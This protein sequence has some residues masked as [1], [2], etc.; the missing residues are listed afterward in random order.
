MMMMM[1]MMM[2]SASRPCRHCALHKAERMWN[3]Q[4]A[5]EGCG[6]GSGGGCG[7][8]WKGSE[9]KL[10]YIVGSCLLY[11]SDAADDMQSVDL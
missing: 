5:V 1:M 9:A 2:M 11:T 10:G 8:L 7:R 4:E 6:G 3:T